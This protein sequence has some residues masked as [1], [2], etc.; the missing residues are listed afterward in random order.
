V[1]DAAGLREAHVWGHDMGTSTACELVA[2]VERRRTPFKLR[3][4]TLMNGSVHIELSSL[5]LSQRLLLT[6]LAPLFVRL[7]SYRTFVAQMRRIFGRPDALDGAALGAMW[8]Q[9]RH[10][11]GQLRLPAILGYVEERAR[12][13]ER[14][15]GALTRLEIPALILWGRRDPVAVPAIAEALAGE[16]PRARLRWLDDLGHYPQ[17]EDP[18][19]VA[20]EVLAFTREVDGTA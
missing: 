19:R 3:S 7:S 10:R 12:F 20:R 9:I 5:T 18:A 2:R 1:L 6:P 4:L 8:S 11:D 14:W 13:R 15:I 16:I 17:L